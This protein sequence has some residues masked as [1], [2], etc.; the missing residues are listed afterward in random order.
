MCALMW[1][2]QAVVLINSKRSQLRP[3]RM[4]VA[5]SARFIRPKDR[6]Y[7]RRTQRAAS[8]SVRPWLA[9][10]RSFKKATRP[11][12]TRCLLSL[13]TIVVAVIVEGQA[14]RA[15]ISI[16]ERSL[17]TAAYRLC[18]RRATYSARTKAHKLGTANLKAS[19]SDLA[20]E[21]LRSLLT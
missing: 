20:G 3:M 14:V 2:L 8:C 18:Q 9:N 7:A 16:S 4:T 15:A 19:L 11:F 21:V 1:R 17:I 6:R 10:V 13:S 5:R 12:A